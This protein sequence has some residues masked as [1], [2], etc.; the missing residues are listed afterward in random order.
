MKILLAKA[1]R[2]ARLENKETVIFHGKTRIA[3]ERI[4]LFKKRKAFREGLAVSPSRRK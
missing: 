3:S 2:R 4:N 1:E